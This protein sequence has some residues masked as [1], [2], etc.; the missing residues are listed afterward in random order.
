LQ[1]EAIRLN[2]L[3][4]MEIADP[5]YSKLV[6]RRVYSVTPGPGADS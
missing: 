4:T 6:W 1:S 3:F 5:L 2:F